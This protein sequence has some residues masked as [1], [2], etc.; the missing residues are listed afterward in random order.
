MP[1]HPRPLSPH[2]QVYRPQITSVLS[3]FHRFAGVA[4]IGGA[5]LL[6]YWLA[7]LAYGPEAFATARALFASWFG[8]LVLFG[9]TVAFWYHFCNGIRHLAWDAGYGFDMRVLKASGIAMVTATL[10]LT[11][12]TWIAAYAMV[13]R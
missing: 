5:L 4:L 1:K 11:L 6:V 9:L 3:I 13:G 12:A 2:L 8:R 10:A 7:A